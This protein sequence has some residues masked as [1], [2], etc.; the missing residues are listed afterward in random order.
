MKRCPKILP[1][2]EICN[3]IGSCIHNFQPTLFG[4]REQVTKEKPLFA[5]NHRTERLTAPA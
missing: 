2:G 3:R 4:D 5:E 1:G